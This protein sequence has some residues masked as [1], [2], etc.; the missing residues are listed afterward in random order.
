M[1]EILSSRE[2]EKVLQAVIFKEDAFCVTGIAN[3]L[4]ISKS[5][6]S[7]YL[8]L[9]SVKNVLKR[10]RSKYIANNSH[11]TRSLKIMLNIIS[12]DTSIFGKYK[13][14]RAAGLFG[15][16][17]K[18]ENTES[19]DTDIWLYINKAPEADL[20]SL[21]ARLRKKI[22]NVK[23]LLLTADKIEKIKKEDPLFYH[24]LSFGSIMLYGEND[25]L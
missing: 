25:V 17:A 23:I 22:R 10:V 21:S 7:K 9:L 13:F 19:S 5:F 8:E 6:V 20:A 2:R 3:A 12:I 16:C 1:R 11:I 14:I 15:S 4:G 24:A 18:G